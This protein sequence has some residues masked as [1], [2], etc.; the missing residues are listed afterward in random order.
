M[1]ATERGAPAGLKEDHDL[2]CAA[3]REAGERVFA[4]YR[5]R[6]V[7]RWLKGDQSPVTEA[8]LESNEILKSRLRGARP[9]YGW[10]SEEC[11]DDERRLSASRVFIIDPVDGTR[12]FIEAQPEF[13]VCAALVEDGKALSAAIYNPVTEEFYEA[14]AGGG[15]RCNDVTLTCPDREELEGA[16]VLGMRHMF[17]HPGWPRPWPEM[18]VGYRCSTQYRFALV[19]K[20]QYHGALALVRKSDWDVAAGSLIAEEAG[21]KVS[22]HLGASYVFNRPDPAQRAR[23]CAA[24]SLYPALIERL[25]HLPED[26]SELVL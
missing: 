24:P 3:V 23:V 1:P 16:Q 22:D 2:L 10:L 12:A 21:A 13:T 17:T 26:L 14:M 15:A 7:R 25:A 18:R 4:L 6:P 20:G 8:D 9:D 11:V 19:A 5:G